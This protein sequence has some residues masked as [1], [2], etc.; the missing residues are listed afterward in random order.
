VVVAVAVV[1]TDDGVTV[2]VDVINS[3]YHQV[4]L[5]RK[6]WEASVDKELL[7]SEG[8]TVVVVVDADRV[9]V[10]SMV[11]V[12]AVTTSRVSLDTYDV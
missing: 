6:C 9:A 3:C 11:V 5:I 1:V 12:D 2:L 4:S 10:S 8:V 7:T